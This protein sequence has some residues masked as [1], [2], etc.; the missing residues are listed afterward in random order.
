MNN[1]TKVND[2]WIPLQAKVFS[3]WVSVQLRGFQEPNFHDVTKDL[4]NGVVLIELAEKLTHKKASRNWDSNP[5]LKVE[6]VQNCDLAIDMFSKDGVK[7]V[8]ISGK[9]ISD[10][11]EKLILGLIW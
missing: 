8:G 2:E 5:T 3:R 4:S 1:L 6:N 10:N 11:N 7:L 9:D